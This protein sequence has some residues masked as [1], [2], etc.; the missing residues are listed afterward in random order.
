M[1]HESKEAERR[2][3]L[4]A[5]DAMAAAARTAP[6]G[7]GLDR[8]ETWILDGAEKDAFVQSMREYGKEI[9]AEFFLRDAKNVDQ[10]TALILFGIEE[11]QHGLNCGY[12]GKATCAEAAAEGI[13]CAFAMTDLGI[14]IGSAVSVAADLRIDNRVMYSAGK[15]AIHIGTF[16]KKVKAAYGVPLSVSG[17]NVFF[18][19]G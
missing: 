18:D 7:R 6:K 8:L 10:A 11:A 1:K 13:G 12:C 9:G 19:R 2:A 4:A 3:V 14:A 17:K 16:S 15:T 5:A